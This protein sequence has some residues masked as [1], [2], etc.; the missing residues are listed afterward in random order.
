MEEEDINFTVK[1]SISNN[2]VI[3]WVV[4]GDSFEGEVST[5]VIKEVESGGIVWIA[6]CISSQKVGSLGVLV[7]SILDVTLE[8]HKGCHELVLS[9]TGGKV[10]NGVDRGKGSR[11]VK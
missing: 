2:V 3:S 1:I 9:A 6:V 4:E 7:T 8:L 11:E 10:D 5:K